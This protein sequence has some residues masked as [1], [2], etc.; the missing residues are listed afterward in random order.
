[1]ELTA[2]Q[3]LVLASV[4]TGDARDEVQPGVYDFDFTIRAKG[5]L[6]KGKDTEKT[7]TS[8]MPHITVLALMVRRMG[9]QR[10]AALAMLQECMTEALTMDVDA[11]E[12]LLEAQP[13]IALAEQQVRKTLA[14]LPKSPVKG[15]V[16]VQANFDNVVG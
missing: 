12:K 8:S 1:M 9:I 16:K 11:R 14:A 10:D 7:P 4:K 15:A 2:L 3:K 5:T 13:E 6:S